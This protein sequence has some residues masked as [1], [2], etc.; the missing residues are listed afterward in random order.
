MADTVPPPDPHTTDQLADALMQ[1]R[2]LDDLEVRR[3]CVLDALDRLR[4]RLSIPEFDDK[5]I[6]VVAM[7]RAFGTVPNGW[8]RLTEA[9][10]HLADHDLP[11]R[12]AAALAHPVVPPVVDG[13][14]L[15]ELER[16]LA[17]LDRTSVP[18]LPAVYHAAAGEHFGPLPPAVHTAWDA[19]RLLT[20]T[21]RPLDGPPRTVR[22]VQ[23]LAAVIPADRGD[24]LRAWLGRQVRATAPSSDAAQADLHA[25]RSRAGGWRKEPRHPAHLLIRIVPSTA[26]PDRVDI[27]CWVNS[28]PA[29]EPRRREERSVPAAEMRLHVATLLDREEARLR[30]HRGGLVLEFILPLALLNEP[31]EDWPRHSAFGPEKVWDNDLGGPPIGVGHPV[32]VRSLERIEALQL[33]RV[34]NERWDVLTDGGAQARVHQCAPGDGARRDWLYARLSDRPDVVLMT[35]G[36]PP[37]DQHGRTELLIGL[38]AGLPLLVWSRSPAPAGTPP[39]LAEDVLEGAPG[40]VL[41]QLTRL[42]SAPG[43]GDHNG[44]GPRPRL[45]VLWDDPNRLPEVPDPI[46]Q[47]DRDA[48]VPTRV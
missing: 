18:E 5:K 9:V 40:D 26:T 28:G 23:E 17:G 47:S 6:H 37:D 33:H 21:N 3:L 20:H 24:P 36:S 13:S 45:A 35:L 27:S 32:V 11:S 14:A 4:L 29:W 39:P 42:R 43:T 1:V 38:Q 48:A 8:R 19:Y 22:F 2:V 46:V 31:V 16:A 12:H 25:S 44:G 7:V 15:H 34:W 41:E 10:Q 30:T